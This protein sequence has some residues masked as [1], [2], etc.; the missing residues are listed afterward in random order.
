M[1]KKDILHRNETDTK[2]AFLQNTDWNRNVC[3][4]SENGHITNSNTNTPWRE[5]STISTRCCWY[6]QMELN[7]GLHT[8]FAGTW[9]LNNRVL[10]PTGKLQQLWVQ[11]P[12]H[13]T[14]AHAQHQTHSQL[15]L[16][17]LTVW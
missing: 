10:A 15:K 6:V 16:T 14:S 17:T 1:L 2:T 8:Q 11:E 4:D 3:F 7:V 12:E 13:S 5:E 9:R